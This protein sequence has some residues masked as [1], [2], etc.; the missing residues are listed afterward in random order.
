MIHRYRQDDAA[1]LVGVIREANAVVA[2]QFNITLDN[3]PKHPSFYTEEWLAKDI[4][5]G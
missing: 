1:Q 3:N 5:R 2:K 4:A